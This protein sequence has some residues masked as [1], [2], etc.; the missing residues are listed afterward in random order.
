MERR[1]LHRG[2]VVTTGGVAE[3]PIL[4]EVTGAL[5]SR[6]AGVFA[7][8]VMHVPRK[9]TELLQK[10]VERV[11]ADSLI[12]FGGG[13]PIDSCKGAAYG[14]LPGRELIHIAVPT[15]LSAAEYT[16]GG[17]VT[18][19]ATR[20]KSSVLYDPRV[21]PR[22]VINDPA[23]TLA[24]PDW[25]WVTT[26]M[27][28]LDHAIECAY[29]IRHQPIS[30]AL[31]SKAIQLLLTHLQASIQTKGEESAAHRGHCL[32]ASWFSIFGA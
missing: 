29:A 19:E 4:K 14:L 28:A 2:L 26:G 8:V 1:D 12:S 3:L 30:D 18:D 6:C 13:S 32:M 16:W 17:G 15:T 31:A 23:L 7:G 11:E 20:V 5:G 9:T 25:L 22:A 10:E 21:M 24:T 27:R